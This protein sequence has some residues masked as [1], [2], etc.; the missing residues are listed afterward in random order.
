LVAP[1]LTYPDSLR[2]R[3][4]RAS[5]RQRALPHLEVHG[6]HLAVQREAGR[7]KGWHVLGLERPER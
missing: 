3:G 5:D 6:V 1:A 4:T 2:L 7:S